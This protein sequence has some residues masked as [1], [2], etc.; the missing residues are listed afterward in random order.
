LIDWLTDLWLID[1]FKVVL[2]G[3][4]CIANFSRNNIAPFLSQ[5][6]FYLLHRNN[7]SHIYFYAQSLHYQH[8]HDICFSFVLASINP[9]STLNVFVILDNFCSF[10]LLHKHILY[11]HLQFV[12]QEIGSWHVTCL[13][14]QQIHHLALQVF[15]VRSKTCNMLQNEIL[16]KKSCLTPCYTV[17]I[18]SATALHE[19]SVLQ[20]GP[21][22]TTFKNWFM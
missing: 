19:K 15:E 7:F 18:F 20:F 13:D 5:F 17:S 10:N 2:H 21:C 16:C 1:W 6:F 8:T 4:T 12:A 3:P 11:S 9:V 22:N 14:L